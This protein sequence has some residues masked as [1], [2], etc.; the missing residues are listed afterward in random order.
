MRFSPLDR[1][2]NRTRRTRYNQ[3]MRIG[4]RK[5]TLKSR[6]SSWPLAQRCVTRRSMPEGQ[7]PRTERSALVPNGVAPLIQPREATL[8]SKKCQR[9]SGAVSGGLMPSL[10]RSGATFGRFAQSGAVR[11]RENLRPATARHSFPATLRRENLCAMHAPTRIDTIQRLD[12]G[13]TR[14]FS[15]A[16]PDR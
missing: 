5:C 9:Y 10:L 1:I 2:G 4:K 13:I 6:V 15:R 16:S 12:V 11:L 8:Y 3:S 7:S 14:R